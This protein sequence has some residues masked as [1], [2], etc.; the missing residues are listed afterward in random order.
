VPELTRQ[1]IEVIEMGW[2]KHC[3][4]CGSTNINPLVFYLP[5]I[6]EC[7]D[8]GYEGAF[9]IESNT[10]AEEI[11]EPYR[12]RGNIIAWVEGEPRT[13]IWDSSTDYSQKTL[14]NHL[15][16]VATT[17]QDNHPASKP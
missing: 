15:K 4:K 10:L 3:P 11:E 6:W 16:S 5:S 7:L 13:D 2:M 8:C 17:A 9:I 12:K 1:Q 14:Q